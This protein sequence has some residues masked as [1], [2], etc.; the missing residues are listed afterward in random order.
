MT[1]DEAI[2]TLTD[3]YPRETDLIM[4]YLQ[5]EESSYLHDGIDSDSYW[6]EMTPD[7]L[8]FGFGGYLVGAGN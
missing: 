1:R 7:F 3:A 6:L 4:E 5:E 2:K 8:L